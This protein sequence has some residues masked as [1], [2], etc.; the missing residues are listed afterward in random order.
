M[1]YGLSFLGGCLFVALL[2]ASP[3]T[4]QLFII[5]PAPVTTYVY[6]PDVYDGE[7]TVKNI[8]LKKASQGY[9]VQSNTISTM[10]CGTGK[11]KTFGILVMEKY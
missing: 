6:V 11:Y 7:N 3:K 4:Q 5:K 2:A 8:I 10:Y 9:R 1:K